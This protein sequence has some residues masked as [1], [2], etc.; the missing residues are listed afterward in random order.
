MSALRNTGVALFAVLGLILMGIGGL[1]L[2]EG[3]ADDPESDANRGY[4]GESVAPTEQEDGGN[5][6]SK[7]DIENSNVDTGD[8]EL[9]GIQVSLSVEVKDLGP[10]EEGEIKLTTETSGETVATH[11]IEDGQTRPFENLSADKVYQLD[12]ETPVTPPETFTIDPDSNST[13]EELELTIGDEFQRANSFSSDWVVVYESIGTLENGYEAVDRNGNYLVSWDDPGTPE[14]FKNFHSAEKEN[15]FTNFGTDGWSDRNQNMDPEV[16]TRSLMG[17]NSL[18][19]VE[20]REYIG[21]ADPYYNLDISHD[22]HEYVIDGSEV[23]HG[24]P[25]TVHVDPETGYILYSESHTEEREDVTRSETWY[26]THDE[27]VDAIP[28]DPP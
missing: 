17:L 20:N 26:R 8:D 24:Y 11:Y 7:E 1:V 22:V 10:V 15:T 27:E 9:S 13:N 23:N 16:N 18:T 14:R 3:D 25:M 4:D 5:S 6:W 12:I 19:G 28:D 2:L 21:T